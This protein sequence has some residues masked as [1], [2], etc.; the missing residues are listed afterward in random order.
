MTFT[1]ISKI[2][3]PLNIK[4]NVSKTLIKFS[5]YYDVFSVLSSSKYESIT[6]LNDE[7]TITN[8]I[9]FSNNLFLK[10]L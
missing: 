6:S 10:I 7:I 4:S 2:K 5:V 1:V 9:I 8:K 3:I